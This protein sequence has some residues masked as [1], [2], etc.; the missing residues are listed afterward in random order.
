VPDVVIKI[1]GSLLAHVEQL[2]A[3]LGSIAHTARSARL[4]IVPGGGPFAEVVRDVDRRL[5]IPDT[6]AHW[7]AILGMDQHAHLLAARLP[8]GAVAAGPAAARRVLDEGHIP[9]LAPSRWLMEADPLP[10]AWAVTSDSIAAWVAGQVNARELI[11]IKAPGAG[12]ADRVDD[13]FARA[14]PSHIVPTIVSAD[15]FALSRRSR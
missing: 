11:L 7:M 12:G 10:H 8:G 3:V 6:A 1:G 2:D 15:E 13:Y 5:G 14:V 9:V 4:L